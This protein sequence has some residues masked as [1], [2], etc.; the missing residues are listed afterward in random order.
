MMQ[1]LPQPHQYLLC[2]VMAL[3]LTGGFLQTALFAGEPTPATAEEV[4]NVR[5][6]FSRA[7]IGAINENDAMAAVQIWAQAFVNEQGIA[8][9]PQPAIFQNLNELRDALIN[10]KVECVNLTTAEYYAMRDLLA[11]DKLI[12]AIVNKSISEEYVVLVNHRSSFQKLTDLKEKKLRAVQTS[13]NSLALV[14][15]DTVLA[16]KGHDHS[17][18]FFDTISLQDKVS[19]AI[20]PVFFGQTDACIVTRNAFHTMAELNPQIARQLRVVEI[21]PPLVPIV[22]GFRASFNSSVVEKFMDEIANWHLSAAGRQIL[23]IFQTDNLEK[24]SPDTL[25]SAITLL[26]EH[27]RFFPSLSTGTTPTNPTQPGQKETHTPEQAM[28]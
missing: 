17:R 11:D 4:T 20:L 9:K 2:L 27:K 19:D 1:R 14:W 21:S 12:A 7:T 25:K 26:A 18:N 16:K 13:R 15:L 23:T 3:L 28:Q 6:G 10:K 5:V 8:A 24:R 22:F